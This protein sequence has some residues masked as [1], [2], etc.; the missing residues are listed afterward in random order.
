MERLATKLEHAKTI[1]PE[2]KLEIT[3]LTLRDWSDC[4]RAGCRKTLEVRNRTA[5]ERLQTLVTGVFAEPGVG[6]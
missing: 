4:A 2:T 1:A 5:R 6:R 3:Q